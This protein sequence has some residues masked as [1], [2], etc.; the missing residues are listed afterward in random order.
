MAGDRCY[1]QAFVFSDKSI[2]NKV[3][4]ES[5]VT[6]NVVEK[7]PKKLI[8]GVEE[9]GKPYYDDAPKS[10]EGFIVLGKM[11][12][13]EIRADRTKRSREHFKKEVWHTIPRSEKKLFRDRKDLKM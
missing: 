9:V 1:L 11:S 13:A 3:V 10:S 5:D 7:F 8:N 2:E 12:D 4:W 6:N